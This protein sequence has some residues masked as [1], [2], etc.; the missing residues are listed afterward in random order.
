MSHTIDMNNFI[1]EKNLSSNK[2][3]NPIDI[4]NSNDNIVNSNNNMNY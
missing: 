2:N 1:S 4:V 3:S